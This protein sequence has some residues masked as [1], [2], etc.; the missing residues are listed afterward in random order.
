MQPD[1]PYEVGGT[2]IA[3]IHG[4]VNEPIPHEQVSIQFEI[5]PAGAS[6]KGIWVLNRT[7]ESPYAARI[8]LE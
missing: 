6:N 3:R 1:G 5:Y 7:I 8:T 2:G 4:A